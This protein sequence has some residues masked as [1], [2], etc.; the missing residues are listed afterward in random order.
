MIWL[1]V[2]LT[3]VTT[4][5]RTWLHG[6][7]ELSLLGLLGERRDYGLSLIARLEEAGLGTIPGGTLYPA[8]L[9]LETTGLVATGREPSASGPPRKYFE[10]TDQGRQALR[11]RTSEWEQFRGRIDAVLAGARS[12]S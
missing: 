12:Q 9:R 1:A 6:L 11:D 10:L 8:L 5:T 4:S 3:T 2:N 7:L